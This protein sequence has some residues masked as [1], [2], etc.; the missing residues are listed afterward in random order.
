MLTLIFTGVRVG[1]CASFLTG[2]PFARRLILHVNLNEH[3]KRACLL[4]I[5]VLAAVAKTCK[6]A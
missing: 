6:L 4:L 2:N 3:T 5:V 1:V